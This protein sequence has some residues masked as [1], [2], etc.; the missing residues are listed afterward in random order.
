MRRVGRCDVASVASIDHGGVSFA[1]GSRVVEHAGRAGEDGHAADGAAAAAH[2]HGHC[3]GSGL[4]LARC[5]EVYTLSA[6]LIGD[7]LVGGRGGPYRNL[8][9]AKRVRQW[10]ETADPGHNALEV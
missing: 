4:D 8:H 10:S 7:V 3:R 6:V 5:L 1:T 2:L 9:A